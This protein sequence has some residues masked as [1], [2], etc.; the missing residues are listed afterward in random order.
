MISVAQTA[1]FC[2][3]YDVPMRIQNHNFLD[4][5]HL[6]KIPSDYKHDIRLQ[7]LIRPRLH[8]MLTIHQ[9]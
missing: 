2:H 7:L 8:S 3:N 4:S 1:I 5:L 9:R 6:S